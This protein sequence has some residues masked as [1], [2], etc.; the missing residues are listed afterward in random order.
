MAK[1]DI[2]RLKSIGKFYFKDDKTGIAF[3][4]FNE[5]LNDL[6]TGIKPKDAKNLFNFLDE[7]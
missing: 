2:D 3:N 7:K 4:D 6:K 5:F 1:Q